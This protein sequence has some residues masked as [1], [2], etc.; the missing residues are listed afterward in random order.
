MALGTTSP[1]STA[2][3]VAGSTTPCV[4]DKL[5][6][7]ILSVLCML[8]SSRDNVFHEFKLSLKKLAQK[9]VK[10]YKTIFLFPGIFSRHNPYSIRFEASKFSTESSI[11]SQ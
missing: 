3:S 5:L 2:F 8:L 6:L 9:F 7:G 4:M 11:R 1:S 10:N